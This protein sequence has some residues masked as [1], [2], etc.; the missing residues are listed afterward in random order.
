MTIGHLLIL[1]CGVTWLA[2]SLGWERAIAVGAEPFVA[3]TILK[4]ALAGMTLPLVWRWVN[5]LR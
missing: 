1:A 4:T 3:A 2:A 5:R